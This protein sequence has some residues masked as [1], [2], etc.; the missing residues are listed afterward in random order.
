MKKQDLIDL[1]GKAPT[2]AKKL[3]FKHRNIVYGW[4]EELTERQSANVIMRM[5]ANRI[6]IPKEWLKK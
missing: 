1:L 2:L 6:K 4:S 5:K 3:N